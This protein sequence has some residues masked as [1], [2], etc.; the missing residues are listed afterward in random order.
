[1]KYTVA[2]TCAAAAACMSASLAQGSPGDVWR[3]TTTR[4]PGPTSTAWASHY[5]NGR[6]GFLYQRTASGAIVVPGMMNVAHKHMPFG[7]KLTF[8]YDGRKACAVVNDRGPYVHGREFD[9]GPGTAVALGFGGVQQVGWRYGCVRTI[10]VR[11]SVCRAVKLPRRTRHVVR[12]C[13][14]QWPS[15]VMR[16]VVK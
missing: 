3:T 1:M 13:A 16:R 9:L 11:V 2:F 6:D 10:R 15:H 8:Y 14:K 5:A 7:T 12:R 4:D